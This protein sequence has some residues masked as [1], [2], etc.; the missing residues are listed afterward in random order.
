MASD[1]ARWAAWLVTQEGQLWLATNLNDVIHRMNREI[2][3]LQEQSA[4]LLNRADTGAAAEAAAERVEVEKTLT[5]R[6]AELATL[7]AAI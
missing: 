1:A 4:T 6:E 3:S 2:V 7:L 5:I